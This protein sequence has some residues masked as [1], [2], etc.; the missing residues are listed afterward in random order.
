[1]PWI[2]SAAHRDSHLLPLAICLCMSSQVC[3]FMDL[4]VLWFSPGCQ[5]LYSLC[6]CVGSPICRTFAVV[7]KQKNPVVARLPQSAWWR[8]LPETRRACSCQAWDTDDV[9]KEVRP[10]L[11]PVAVA[12]GALC[13][14][15][16]C[17]RMGAQPEASEPQSPCRAWQSPGRRG[18]RHGPEQPQA[19]CSRRA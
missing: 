9:A 12:L 4:Y 11:L 2:S 18:Q 7:S 14:D 10:G 6:C 19:G 13:R 3:R 1:V 17:S 5:T 8:A 15:C 16:L